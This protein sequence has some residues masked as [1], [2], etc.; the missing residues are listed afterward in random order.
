MKWLNLALLLSLGLVGCGQEAPVP[1]TW[2]EF[3]AT[4]EQ[5]PINGN[6][7]YDGDQPAPDLDGLRAA[8][9]E[10][11]AD[12]DAGQT[13]TASDP[14]DEQALIVNLANGTSDRWA[15][16]TTVTYCVSK[17]SFG[18]QYGQVVAHVEAAL[19]EWE[20]TG[21]NVHYTHVVAEDGNGCN[22]RNS[23]VTFNVRQTR[24]TSYYAAAFFPSYART[25]RELLISTISYN[26]QNLGP[27]TLRGILR[28]EL[29]HS[30]G[31]RHEHIRPENTSRQATCS[32][33]NTSWAALTPYDS[34]SVMHYPHNGCAGTNTGDLEITALDG[35]GARALYP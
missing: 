10:Y 7:Y 22:N 3:R 5:D 21:A 24:S 31:F 27:W 11:L 20:S 15:D 14:G 1:F 19:G 9:D 25:S 34:A 18:A 8:Y 6:Y 16:G 12:F 17:K 28:H 26:T 32:T 4:A 29:G 2:D 13:I 35:E 33:E 23:R 30:L